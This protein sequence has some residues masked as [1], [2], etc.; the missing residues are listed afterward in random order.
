MNEA[1]NPVRANDTLANERTYL[2]Y[3]RTA[4]AFI[5]FGFVIAR[6]SLFTREFSEI[7]HVGLP[8]ESVSTAFGTGM[9]AFGIL[10][11]LVGAWRYDATDRGLS[12]GRVVRLSGVTGYLISL[13][14]VVV[15]AIVAFDLLSF[16]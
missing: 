4:L 10:V 5:A 16:H 1:P 7:A 3:V 2:A 12:Q 13:F 6:F 15:G 14:V 11:A 8:K 9:A